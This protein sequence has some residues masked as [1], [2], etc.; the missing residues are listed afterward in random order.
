LIAGTLL[1][2]IVAGM[3]RQ[4]GLGNGYGAL[5]VSSWAITAVQRFDPASAGHQLGLVAVVAIGCATIALLRMR[6]G[7]GRE[8]TL[9]VPTS[10]VV[11]F[12]TL[13]SLAALW[14]VVQFRLAAATIPT[15]SIE[16]W[17]ILGGYAVPIFVVL[18][19]LWS[20]VLSRPA[21]V[22]PLAARARLAPPSRASW[23]RA[24]LLSL[25]ILLLIGAASWLAFA[26]HEDARLLCDPV[27]AMIAA[28]VL[29][30][31]VDDL[32][33]RRVALV[34]AWP[35]HQAQHAELVSRVL[36]DAGIACHFQASHL[37]T[38]LA[39]FGPYVPID[40]LVP[41]AAAEDA[42]TRIRALFHGPIEGAPD[43]RDA[44]GPAL[45]PDARPAPPAQP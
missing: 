29:L 20:L 27:I 6:T 42:R 19:P 22:A 5:L 1:L 37:R 25:V 17:L 8:A 31:G 38:L 33:A 11:P 16:V 28:A 3:I 23:R 39:F 45:P 12:T 43:T 40:V 2:V 10:G 41:A 15:S 32:R 26:I 21:I 7:D 34:V 4:H 18:V 44:A 36:A 14:A 24:T 35:L 9:R 30:D 13:G